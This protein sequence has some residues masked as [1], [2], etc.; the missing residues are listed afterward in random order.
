MPLKTVIH[1]HC[2]KCGAPKATVRD[3]IVWD[4]EC[5]RCPRNAGPQSPPR[6]FRLD[7]I[8]LVETKP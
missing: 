6:S 8:T 7:E 1:I 5:P 4:G 2:Q 3:K